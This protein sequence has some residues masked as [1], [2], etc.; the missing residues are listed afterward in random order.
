MPAVF[1]SELVERV[2]DHRAMIFFQKFAV[3]LTP[4]V[5]AL[6]VGQFGRHLRESAI[7][8]TASAI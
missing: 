4:I 6:L 7:H 2:T 5:P 1:P 8:T 3:G